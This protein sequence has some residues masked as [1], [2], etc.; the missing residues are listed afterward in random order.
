[1]HPGHPSHV[2]LSHER[3]PPR[4]RSS[5]PLSHDDMLEAAAEGEPFRHFTKQE[6]DAH[7]LRDG[8][9]VPPPV[10]K[11]KR[12]PMITSDGE[13]WDEGPIRERGDL[14][15]HSV[16]PITTGMIPEDE[17][18]NLFDRFFKYSHPFVPVFDPAED[19]FEK[20]VWR[21]L[22]EVA[23]KDGGDKEEG[24]LMHAGCANPRC[25]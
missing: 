7:I 6:E 12:A 9:P 22:S 2:A 20:Y 15:A 16:D 13:E 23:P 11:R 4:T 21:K 5:S 19:T 3:L 24:K 17:A 18:R 8:G 1:M 25:A 10:R 14:L